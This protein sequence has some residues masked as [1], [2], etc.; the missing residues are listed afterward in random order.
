MTLSVVPAMQEAQELDESIKRECR[1]IRRSAVELAGFLRQAYDYRR[2]VLLDETSIL[3]RINRIWD[4]HGYSCWSEYLAQPGINIPESKAN[5]I[6]AIETVIIP[7]LMEA[8]DTQEEAVEKLTEIDESKLALLVPEIRKGGDAAELVNWA[9]N[10]SWREIHNTLRSTP[11]YDPPEPIYVQ[12][13]RL[14]DDAYQI[15]AI[16]TDDDIV[17]LRKAGVN[18]QEEH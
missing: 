5:Y 17:R 16:I 13:R 4:E 1:N 14:N 7:K 3:R 11:P 9:A 12:L 6:M 10:T 8:G 15:S 2:E 18:F